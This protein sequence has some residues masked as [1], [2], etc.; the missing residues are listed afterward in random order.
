MSSVAF[1]RISL[2]SVNIVKE[3]STDFHCLKTQIPKRL[4]N[5]VGKEPCSRAVVDMET[6]S[7]PC[8]YG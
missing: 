4:N 7:P 3:N 6:L 1:K 5:K 2:Y 8:F